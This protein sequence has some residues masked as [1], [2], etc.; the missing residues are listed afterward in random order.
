[1]PLLRH[2]PLRACLL[3]GA[4]AVSSLVTF[5]ATV[6]FQPDA[7]LI[8]ASERV[9][10]GR[11]LST[12]GE[13][14][15]GGRIYTV[16]TV[17]V[18]EDFSGYAQRVLEIRELG[19]RV[20]NDFLVVGGAVQYEP[21]TEIVVCLERSSGGWLRS[22][23][24]GF[25]KFDVIDTADGDALLQRNLE[26]T[27]VVG[28]TQ[29]LSS[30]RLSE[31]RRL[32]ERVRGVRAVG[33]LAA[34]AT[35]PA[36]SIVQPF[37]LLTFGNGLGARW[38]EADTGT[39]VR[40]FLDTSAAP[41]VPG[42][43]SAELQTAL[44]G[45]TNPP[46]ASIVLGYAGETDQSDTGG[47]W[48]ALG[49]GAGV[50]FFEDPDNEIS[51]SVLAVGGGTGTYNDGGVVNGTQFN[52]FRS[53]FVIFQ[54][55]AAL[56]ESFRQ[57][58]NFTR[59]LEHEIGHGIG[60]GHTQTSISNAT[61]NIMYAS[62]CGSSTPVPPA[63]GPDD[64]AGLT[65]I[66]PAE[67]GCTYTLS[68]NSASVAA[69]A[70]SFGVTITTQASCAWNVS[71]HPSWIT[72]SVTS[73]TGN[74]SVQLSVATNVTTST[75]TTTFAI[76]GQPF[77]VNQQACACTVTP[78]STSVLPRGGVVTITIS[79]NSCQWT[80]SSPAQWIVAT[81]GTTGSG[82]GTV[83]FSASRNLGPARQAVLTVAGR[84]VTVTQAEDTAT[85]MDFDGDGRADLAWHHQTDGRIAVWLMNGTTM[86]SGTLLTPERVA[87]TNWKVV[88]IWDPDRDGYPDLL[89]QHQTNG[90]LAAWF[91]RGT[92]LLHGDP[93]T[94]G[95]VADTGWT[96]VATADMNRD[97]HTDLIWQHTTQG[98][99]SA[100]LMNGTTLVD[101]RLLSPSTVSDTNWRIVGSGDF[102]GDGHA[103]LVW[104]HQVTGQAS[105]WFMNGTTQVSGTLLSPAGVSDT[106]WQIRG[107]ADLNGDRQP[108][109]IWQNV[110]TGYVAAWLMRGLTMVDGVYLSPA[111]VA[112]TGWRIAG[113]R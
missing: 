95:G 55:A 98:L 109:L 105:V 33:P 74:G 76:G 20:G 17:E 112:D 45:W 61:S 89:W 113:P 11:V 16:T 10:R 83:S 79:S 99:V 75:R 3:I 65:F 43:A 30:P 5:A 101:G 26:D 32:A 69:L 2:T 12:R 53:G 94:P 104:H 39:V 107:V 49:S 110:A 52:R 57:S 6:R 54:N 88:G 22:V 100:W 66:Y 96:I 21:G 68:T 93:L 4:L 56:P 46:Q 15:A 58:L 97:G 106:N 78:T 67:S 19:G 47:P 91:M 1:M 64:L 72:P 28:N 41:P 80:A 42:N 70:S 8:A 37:T 82:N 81:S 60:L 92:T 102:D 13:R 63:I 71:G 35:Q 48:A 87:D 50:V 44:A 31:F 18:I 29:A 103:D 9:V 86:V 62:C 59:V 84:S 38:T 36:P 27:V 14:G 24:M 90:G 111:V 108:D 51:G 25:S 73:G 7:E 77:T 34:D 40:W 23:A 85:P